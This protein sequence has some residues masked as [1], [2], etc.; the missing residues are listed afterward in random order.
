MKRKKI[1]TAL[2]A[3]LLVFSLAVPAAAVTYPDLQGQWAWAKPYMEDL[4]ARGIMTGY[5]DGTMK[6]GNDITGAEALAMLSRL[7]DLTDDALGLIYDDYGSIAEEALPASLSWVF[8]EAAVCLASGAIRGDELKKLD[9]E[10]P[11]E[12]E[13][14]SVLLV[15]AMLLTGSLPAAIPTFAD[16]DQITA[17]Y[18]PY[19]GSRNC[20]GGRQEQ[21]FSPY[22][23]IARRCRHHVFKS[24]GIS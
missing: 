9:F 4:A 19:G 24:P 17:A 8:D 1:G 15:R 22:E 10:K 3:V 14:L 16:T 6:P 21:F 18:R 2:I 23:R 7:Y 13:V 12:K 5:S 11:I 20:H